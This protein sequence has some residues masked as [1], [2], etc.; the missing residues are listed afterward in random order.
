M[1]NWN[2]DP[3]TGDYIMRG[4]A[5][6][7]TDSLLVPVF[8]RLRIVRGGWLYAPNDDYGS[9]FA[10][11][12]KR[13]T[14]QDATLIENIAARALNPIVEDG[15]ASSISVDTVLVTRTAVGLETKVEDATGQVEKLVLPAI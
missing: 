3:K 14:S 4:G 6:E 13:K 10:S 2:K 1:Q 5:P 8:H 12:K 11:V 7:Q 9:D 15:R